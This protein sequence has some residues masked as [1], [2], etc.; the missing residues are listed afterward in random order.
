MTHTETFWRDWSA[1]PAGRTWT[2]AVRRRCMTLKALTYAPTGGI[3]AAPTTS[4]P[5]QIGGARNWDYR[6]C[7]L[8]DAT[9][10][11]LALMHAGYCDEAQAWRDW[12]C[13]R[14]PAARRRLQ[15]MYGIGGERR[16]AGM[17][18]AWLPGYEDSEPVRIGNAAAGQL[19]LDVYGEV[20]DALLGAAQRHAATRTR[21]A[22]LQVAMLEHLGEVWREPD[23]GIWEV[24]GGR[25]HFTH[26]KVMAWVGIRPR[27]I[28]RRDARRLEA[29]LAALAR[30]RD[31]IHA[32]IC[33]NG[34]DPRLG[35]FVQTYGVT[36]LDASLL[37]IPLVGFLPAERSA[38]ARH[39][40][41]DRART[42]ARRPRD[43]LRVPRHGGRRPAAGEGAFLAC[44]FWLADI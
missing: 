40:R 18:T 30:S 16:L 1:Q 41:G 20:M 15:I 38:R 13:A 4:L 39:A 29:P 9:F 11:L 24:R 36:E 12:L 37:L 5:E 25:Q 27:G 43:A 14:S 31:E 28:T 21:L 8:R 34:F 10:T 26:S 35:S 23:E 33:A 3:V 17:G 44:S 2:D 22:D 6:Y 32:D 19:Q 7:W 42:D